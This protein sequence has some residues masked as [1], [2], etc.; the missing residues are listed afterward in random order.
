MKKHILKSTAMALTCALALATTSAPSHAQEAFLGEIRFTGFDFAPR[1]WAKC[2]GQLMPVAG[3]ESLYSILGT[4]FGGDGVTTFAL[5]DMRGRAPAHVGTSHVDVVGL[6]W[7]VDA[8]G[9]QR[10]SFYAEQD[11]GYTGSATADATI[12]VNCI[13]AIDGTFPSRN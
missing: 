10:A 11:S 6:G 12:G 9:D 5:P 7:K 2:D 4:S 13:I 8:G 1:G 3:N